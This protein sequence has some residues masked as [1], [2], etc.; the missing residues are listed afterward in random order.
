MSGQERPLTSRAAQAANGANGARA[1]VGT[2]A[3]VGALAAC[4][5][6]TMSPSRGPAGMQGP[7]LGALASTSMRVHLI[8]VGQGAATLIEFPCAAVLVDTGG[9]DNEDFHGTVRLAQ[10]LDAFFAGRPDLDRTLALLVIT[11]PHIDHTRGA[12]MVVERYR[13]K[14]L[15][16]DGFAR[17]DLGGVEQ[18]E[19]QRHAA[20]AKI[21][22]FAA[23]AALV[24]A[25]GLT[26]AIIDPVVCPDVDPRIQVLWGSVTDAEVEWSHYWLENMNNQSVVLRVEVGA[27]ALLISGDLQMPG[28]QALLAKHDGTDALDVDVLGVSHHGAWNGVSAA[29]LAALTPEIALIACGDARRELEWTAW[30]YGHPRRGVV[31]LLVHAVTGKRPPKRVRVAEAVKRFIVMPIYKAVYATS[32][33][34]DVIVEMRADGSNRVWTEH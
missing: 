28:I 14:N 34:G 33:D 7:A 20:R 21:P 13:V 26:S 22:F 30:A 29:L 16:T 18:T 8:D 6:A 24:P 1:F 32:W 11:H 5:H 12:R 9:E 27:S 25:G 4:A 10:Y 3:F 23:T 31:E 17:A 2:L 19:L 15:V